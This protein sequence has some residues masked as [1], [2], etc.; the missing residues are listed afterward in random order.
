MLII[1]LF[2][3]NP[4]KNRIN[5]PNNKQKRQRSKTTDEINVD[6]NDD[7]DS[8]NVSVYNRKFGDF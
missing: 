6:D 7:N 4:Q 3:K 8:N 2:L 1:K 5:I